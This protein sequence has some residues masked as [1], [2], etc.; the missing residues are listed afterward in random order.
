MN[1]Y[2]KLKKNA[3]A[4]SPVVASIILIAVTV[5]VS[6]VVAAWMSGMTIG[7]MGNAET[8]TITNIGFSNVAGVKTLVITVSN[9]GNSPVTITNAYVNTVSFVTG[10]VST[11]LPNEIA[12]QS[13]EN[14]VLSGADAAFTAGQEYTVKMTTAKGN[15][16]V[17]SAFAP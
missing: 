15:N 7:L 14:M 2:R 5:A 10:S 12:K 8:A 9:T 3:K 6:V 4:L 16:L 1:T 13:S 17:L 11:G